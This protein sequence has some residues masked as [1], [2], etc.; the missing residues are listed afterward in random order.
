MLLYKRKISFSPRYTPNKF[1]PH[2]VVTSIHK[3]KYYSQIYRLTTVILSSS[4]NLFIRLPNNSDVEWDR[5]VTPFSYGLWL[6]VAFTFCA[7]SV[8]LALINYGR[9]RNQNLTLSTILFNIHSCFCRQ[10]QSDK[11]CCFTFLDCISFNTVP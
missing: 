7:I 10:G 4:T 9:E 3:R 2:L 8:C 6:A 11:S 5:Y 1:L